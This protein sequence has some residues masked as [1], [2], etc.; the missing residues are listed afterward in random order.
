MGWLSVPCWP[1]FGTRKCLWLNGQGGCSEGSSALAV[2][3]LRMPVAGIRVP[4][5]RILE[6]AIW[7]EKQWQRE[8]YWW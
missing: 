7:V 1:T 8:E 6:M 5:G 2:A 4:T 3:V